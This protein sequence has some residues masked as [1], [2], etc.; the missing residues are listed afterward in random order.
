MSEWLQIILLITLLVDMGFS[1]YDIK[2]ND[3]TY[4]ALQEWERRLD[5]D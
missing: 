5:N 3:K 1:I 2:S 4:K